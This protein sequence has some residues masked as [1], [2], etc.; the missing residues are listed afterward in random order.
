MTVTGTSPSRTNWRLCGCDPLAEGRVGAS[1]RNPRA[2]RIC[3][4]VARRRESS[5]G[6][7]VILSLY[8]TTRTR[9]CRYLSSEVI[10]FGQLPR[11][12]CASRERSQATASVLAGR[13]G[14][15]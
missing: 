5:E 9:H 6:E 3:V 15:L 10:G 12:R 1:P 7:S 8:V 11:V 2:W 4:S 14:G 13:E